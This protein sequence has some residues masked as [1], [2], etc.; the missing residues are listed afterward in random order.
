[1]AKKP[2]CPGEKMPEESQLKLG[3]KI[4]I[5]TEYNNNTTPMEIDPSTSTMNLFEGK[6]TKI[7]QTNSLCCYS[8]STLKFYD[9]FPLM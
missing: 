5:L 7:L 1:M 3:N 4:I 2:D 6:I 8:Y 9:L